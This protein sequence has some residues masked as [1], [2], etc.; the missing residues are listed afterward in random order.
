MS[1][2]LILIAFTETTMKFMTMITSAASSQGSYPPPALF[3][4]I[5]ELARDANAA[6]VLVEQGGLMPIAQGA[7]FTLRKGEVILTDGPFAEAKEL[8]GGYAVYDV[9]T[10][11]EALMWSRRFIELHQ[12]HWPEWEGQIEIRQIM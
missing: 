12:Q 6:G 5:A 9:P 4:G 10:K 3:E 2:A 7:I 11:E 1:Q 8:V